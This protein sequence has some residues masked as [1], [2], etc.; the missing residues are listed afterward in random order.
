M[1]LI[2]QST[3]GL[4]QD[5]IAGKM[6]LHDQQKYILVRATSSGFEDKKT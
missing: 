1:F 6:Q 2:K 4:I 3:I 5:L